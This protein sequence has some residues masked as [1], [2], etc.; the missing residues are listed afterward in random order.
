MSL[1]MRKAGKKDI[2]DLCALMDEMSH[3][4]ISPEQMLNRLQMVGKSRIDSLYV[5]EENEKVVGL[6]GFRIRENLEELS[7]FGEIS[8]IVV[9]PDNKRKGI[10]RFMMDYAERLAKEFK[11]KGMWLVSGFVRKE[12]AHKFYQQLGFQTTG[13]R[14]VKLF[15]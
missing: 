3:T 12:E 2:N 5:C 4:A 8:A 13:Y 1:S 7:R 6:L 11:C 9:Y 15:K 14:F 10:G